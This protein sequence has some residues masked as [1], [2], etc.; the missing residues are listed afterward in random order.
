[1]KKLLGVLFLSVL[2]GVTSCKKTEITDTDTDV[3]SMEALKVPAGFTWESSKDIYFDINITDTRFGD[4]YHVVSIYDADPALN[5]K[6][7]SRGSASISSAFATKIYLPN[8]VKEVFVVKTAPNGTKTTQKV[9]ITGE[10]LTVKLS[11]VSKDSPSNIT[12]DGRVSGISDSP[13][14]TTG[15]TTT[16]TT[17]TQ[18]LEVQSGQ[19]VCITGSNITVSFVG[20]GG[21]IRICGTNVTMNGGLENDAQLVIANGAT[22]TFNNFNVN[23]TGV[24]K[25]Y[26]NI[27]VNGSF[28]PKSLFL[29]ENTMHV[30]GDFN[31]NSNTDFTNNGIITVGQTMNV[32]TGTVSTNNGSITTNNNFELNAQSTFVNNCFLWV[33]NNYNHNATMKNYSLIKVNATTT[34]NGNS[35]IG[36]YSGAM[37]S[38]DNMIINARVKGYGSTSLVKVAN[39]STINGGS[40]VDALQYC[41]ANGIETNNG[42]FSGG[43]AAACSVYIPKTNCNTEGNGT[44]PITD[45]DGDGVN[46]PDDEYPTDPTKAYNNYYPSSSPTSGATVAFEDQWPAKGDYDMNDVVVSYRYKI[47]TNAANKVVQV[48]GDYTLHATGGNYQNGFGI[49]FP[50]TRAAATGL[51]GGTL[52]TGQTKAV[53]I[54]FTN[55]RAEMAQWNTRETDPA[56]AVKTYS[57]SFNVTGAPA[58][59]SFGLGSYNPF[60]YNSSSTNGRGYEIHLPSKSPTTKANTALFGTV[61]DNSNVSAARYYQTSTG[62]PWAI[63]I[64]VKPF[65]YPTEQVQIVSGYLRFKNWAE[66]GGS[67]YADWYSNIGAGYR[68]T[69]NLYMP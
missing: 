3:T 31:L 25:N 7:L 39:T 61:D 53:V 68:N 52:E 37:L 1:M 59:S 67:Q 9:T 41:D 32:N 66:S 57:I 12:A 64:P 45:T 34:V 55:M 18:N 16:I 33:K 51:T 49:E 19:T 56:S 26:G 22:V 28:A 23:G 69:D 60:I 54:L 42:T 47:V 29:N 5:G 43:A 35:E 36:M 8:T 48:N 50:I 46:D 62:L 10:K 38:T 17:S 24:V 14:C 4:A 6:L 21:M 27:T 15:C 13:T 65:T 11:A 63:D 44:A 2:I 30:T 58:L 20:R 40:L